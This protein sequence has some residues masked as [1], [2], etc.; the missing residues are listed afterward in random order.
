MYRLSHSKSNVK[1]RLN[2]SDGLLLGGYLIINYVFQYGPN[3]RSG[4][5]KLRRKFRRGVQ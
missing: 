2:H 1:G 5:G 3:G 4:I